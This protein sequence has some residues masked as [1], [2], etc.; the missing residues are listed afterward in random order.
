MASEGGYQAVY[1]GLTPNLVGNSASW[2]L[3]F[4]CYDQTKAFV[5]ILRN[6]AE[7]SY[8]DF[9]LASGTAGMLSRL[10]LKRNE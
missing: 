1:R 9:F 7:L 4:L 10:N 6:G 2:A 3:Y 8:S 5:S